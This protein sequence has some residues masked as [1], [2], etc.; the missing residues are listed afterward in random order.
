[1]LQNREPLLANDPK[2]DSRLEGIP[3][4][5]GVRSLLCL[6]LLVEGDLRGVLT[7]CNKRW[8]AGFT[9][10]DQRLMGILASQAAQIVENAR[11]REKGQAHQDFQEELRAARRIQE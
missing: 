3:W 6:P 1:M 2:A 10:G 11:L 8:G 5:G 7:V 9:S 4:N